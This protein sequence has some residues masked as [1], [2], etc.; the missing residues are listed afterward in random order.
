MLAEQAAGLREMID[1]MPLPVWRRDPRRRLVDCNR[2]YAAALDAPREA[3]LAEAAN[4]R[5][6]AARTGARPRS[7]A[8]AGAPRTSAHVVDQRRRG[9]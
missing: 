6:S 7:A 9:G 5:P 8:A 3:V 4:S 2:A 1:A